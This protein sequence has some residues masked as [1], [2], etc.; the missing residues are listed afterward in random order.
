MG[1]L[2]GKVAVVTGASKGIGA[3]IAR[4]LGAE[5]AA[6]VV[7]Y[8]SDRDGALRVVSDIEAKGGKA[9]AV[10]ADVSKP[11]DVKRLFEDTKSAF[12]RLDVLVNNAGVYKFFPIQELTEAE[13]NRQFGTNVF[14]LLQVTKEA[15]AQFGPGG[16]SIIN[17]GSTGTSMAL[18]ETSVY[19]ATKGAVDTITPVLAK[20]LAPRK[21]RVNSI[22]PG[23]VET[24]GLH[25][26]GVPGSEFEKRMVEQT[27]LGRLG[28]P[29]DI[30]PIAVFLAS[31]DSGW[32]TGEILLAS[33]GLR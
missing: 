33:G 27:P 28:Q 14:G 6:V 30:A 21:I 13:F 12:G 8:A 29:D 18:P 17:I 9:I 4:G 2:A 22:N 31:S 16:G 25:T 11:A 19:T 20:E 3:G 15:V 24:E 1:K 26:A 5:G 32:L 10:Q 7:N 23:G